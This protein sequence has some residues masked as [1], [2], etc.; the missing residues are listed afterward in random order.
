VATDEQQAA[1][2]PLGRLWRGIRRHPF[3]V[4]A[5][6]ALVAAVAVWLVFFVFAFHLVFIDDKVDEANP[7]ASTPTST[8]TVSGAPPSTG[9]VGGTA[10]PTPEPAAPRVI[11]THRGTFVD[12]SHPASGAAIVIT[13]GTTAFLRF[14]DFKTDN[15]PDL[16]V[17]LSAGVTSESPAGALD[18]DFVDLGRLKGNIGAQNYELPAGIDLTRYRTVVVWCK[19]FTTA[20]GAA[21]LL[22]AE[23]VAT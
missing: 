5:S 20:F 8:P 4:S 15:G 10:A 1:T 18:D 17:Y 11:E 21:D 6:G 19:R 14:E 13:D 3:I 7:F 16:F 2:G 12:R 23:R 9:P 22:A